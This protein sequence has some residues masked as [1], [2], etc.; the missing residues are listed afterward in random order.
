[1]FSQSTESEERGTR[2]Y[3]LNAFQIDCSP[4]RDRERQNTLVDYPPQG[5][6]V[7]HKIPN[8]VSW[9][10]MSSLEKYE[11]GK[12]S[13]EGLLSY[14]ETHVN[15]SVQKLDERAQYVQFKAA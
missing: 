9:S 13:L 10:L 14:L 12:T 6:I 4:R 5:M 7:L 15:L 3:D 2:Q 11:E 1:M 8:W